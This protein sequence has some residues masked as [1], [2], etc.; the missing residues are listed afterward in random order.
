M[1]QNEP[2]ATT[3]TT[4]T[5]AARLHI[6]W[7]RCD[8]RGLCVELL[9]ELLDRDQWGFPEARSTRDRSDLPIP[10]EL[11]QAARDAVA[12]CPLLALRLT[13]GK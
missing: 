1:P 11:E 12:L 8:G 6:D 13:T 9:P 5:T 2:T 4:A 3:A 7:T 10:V